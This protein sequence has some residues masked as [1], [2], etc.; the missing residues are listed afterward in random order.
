MRL[1]VWRGFLAVMALVSAAAAYAG[2]I[3]AKV[4][5]IPNYV[6]VRP[7]LASA[8]QP[9]PEALPRLKELGFGTVVNLRM[10]GEP[11]FVDE[12]KALAAQ[13]VRYVQVPLT[14]ATFSAADV[15]AVRKVLDDPASGNV[16]IHCHSGNRV[17]GVWAAILAAQGKSLDQ[18]LEEGR[19]AGLH[20]EAMT[21]AVRRV[22]GAP[23]KK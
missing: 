10:P 8:G 12:A 16:L 17:G 18:A 14:A 22:A 6:V 21:E 4:D 19:R 2:E 11:D 15:A 23:A 13:G 1:G 20:S 3:P 9:S 5:S 7:G